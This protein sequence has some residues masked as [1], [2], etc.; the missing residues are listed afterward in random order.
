MSEPTPL[1]DTTVAAC[2]G[3]RLT[4]LLA[5][6][7]LW[8]GLATAPTFAQARVQIIH[9]SPDP[10][11]STVDIYVDNDAS[12]FVDDLSFRGATG[13]VDVP[14]GTREIDIA[15]QNSSGPGDAVYTQDVTVQDG[16]TYVAIATGELALSGTGDGDFQLLLKTDA[17]ESV[18]TTDGDVELFGVHGSPDAP[19]VDVQTNDGSTTLLDDISY[20]D[21]Q[22]PSG[23]GY[24]SIGAGTYTLDVN[25]SSSGATAATFQLDLS[26]SGD[27]VF[28]VL[29]S[30]YDT[31]DDEP[32]STTPHDF[33]LIAV[34]VAGNVIS[35][36]PQARAQIIHNSPDPNASSVDIYVDNN[37]DALV[38]GLSFRDATGYVTVQ[39]GEREIDVAPDGS[40][41]PGDAVATQNVQLETGETYAIIASGVLTPSNF[42]SN[43]SGVDTGFQLLAIPGAREMPETSGNAEFFVVHGAPDAPPVDA[44]VPGGPTLAD[45]AAYT[46]ATGYASVPTN[47][48]PVSVTGPN[49]AISLATFTA[50]L[51][52][53]GTAIVVASGF[54]T[55]YNDPDGGTETE[56]AL[57]LL[58]VLADGTTTLLP[59]QNPLAINEFLAD[60]TTSSGGV[61]ANGDGTVDANGDEFVEIINRSGSAVDLSGYQIVDSDGN[62]YTFPTN[63]TIPAGDAATIFG[64]GTPT[65]IP[66]FTDTGLPALNNGGDDILLKDDQG[67]VVQSLTYPAPGAVPTSEGVSTARNVNAVGGFAPQNAFGPQTAATP[68]Q[69][70]DSGEALPVE[71]AGFSARLDGTDAVLTWRTLS[72]RNN[73]GFAVQHRAGD[74][75]FEKV[76]FREGQGTTSEPRSYRFR[77]EE[78]QPGAH[79]FRLKQVDTDGSSSLTEVVRVEVELEE[80][81]AWSKVAPN[82]VSGTG[83]VSM[84]V[85]K[86]QDVTVE[87]YDLLGRQV[88]TLHEGSLT[89]GSRHQITLDAGDL[90][91]GTYLL[92]ADGEVFSDTQRIV[93]VK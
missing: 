59:V 14:A 10:R 87:L 7:L 73:S 20:T 32:F 35:L 43:P 6:F 41:G 48:Y 84:Q 67:D 17:Q 92:R 28:T 78:L 42:E 76:G 83:A 72:E 71:L 50:P 65:G 68:G 12:P 54:Y 19:T 91:G 90:A 46:D 27:Q 64:G 2:W 23:S 11:A 85:R 89:A 40:S 63:T 44:F 38:E 75:A 49:R 33:R 4:I 47:T 74:G 66:G 55:P 70:N 22:P 21:L 52:V 24:A 62:S 3:R 53:P 25:V 5:A 81:F 61:D 30:G 86:T 34:D 16:E 60:P 18:A 80:A 57:G 56:P 79:A 9:N 69:N 51:P 26:G 77:V 58:A 8:S 15:P 82:P 36:A 1:P 37:S 29:A 93:I 31:P 13:Y 88:R 39:A 45:D